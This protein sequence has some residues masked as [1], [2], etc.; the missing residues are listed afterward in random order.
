MLE[1]FFCSEPL[2]LYPPLFILLT[3]RYR[4][5]TAFDE[6]TILK[7][8]HVF[9]EYCK[10]LSK[11]PEKLELTGE[12]FI[13]IPCLAVNPLR[14]QFLRCIPSK[15]GA[16]NHMGNVD[17]SAFMRL[18]AVTNGDARVAEKLKFAFQ[19][20]DMD[21]DGKI[22]I[23]DLV[24]YLS[25]VTDFDE[26]TTQQVE[27]YQEFVKKA[28]KKTFEELGRDDFLRL[29]DFAK[30]LL[31]SDFAHKYVLA[32]PL[33][34]PLKT[35]QKKIDKVKVALEAEKQRMANANE[36]RQKTFDS[37]PEGKELIK[38][39]E[40]KE[41]KDK[42]EAEEKKK[43]EEEEKK[44][45]E[46]EKK[47]KEE[48][49]KKKKEEERIKKEKAAAKAAATTAAA[50]AAATT[51]QDGQAWGDEDDYYDGDDYQGDY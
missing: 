9:K 33:N 8:F 41:E 10:C 47:Q 51:A 21:G 19:M 23:D 2:F 13:Q 15:S 32:M 28:A 7:Y 35:I 34:K 39:K 18:L 22:H 11:E 45:K 27:E 37:T 42:A 1:L 44:K 12:E 6:L 14:D 20:Y 36:R 43:K 25:L 26:D 38:E 29:E 30:T 46:E 4:M 49:E 31:H 16:G 24:G 3:H 40:E 5:E 50:A 48:E 17:F